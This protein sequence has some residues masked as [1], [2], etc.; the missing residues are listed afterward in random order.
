MKDLKALAAQGADVFV[1][2]LPRVV[3]GGLLGSF[4]WMFA[5]SALGAVLSGATWWL[6]RDMEQI[7]GWLRLSLLLTPLVLAFAG[8]YVGALRGILKALIEQMNKHKLM[9]YVYAQVK[10]AAL[11]ALKS[12]PGDAKALA[13]ATGAQ[14]KRFL[15]EDGDAPS[16]GERLARST[17]ARAQRLLATSFVDHLGQAESHE[18]AV[19]MVEELGVQKLEEIAADTLSDLFS[20]QVTV[21]LA[22]SLLVSLLPQGI[23]WALR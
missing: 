9:A 10:P 7:P 14:M 12:A 1:S 11:A 8:I 15:D 6:W 22:L 2:V 4:K 18:E 21:V 5:L 3:L 19:A 16:F 13:S 23:W 20:L 17:A